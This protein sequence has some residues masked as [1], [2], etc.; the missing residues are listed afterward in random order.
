MSLASPVTEPKH[1]DFESATRARIDATDASVHEIRS[2]VRR[3]GCTVH[4]ERSGGRTDLVV[5]VR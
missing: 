2:F 1:V 3:T 4:F 5:D